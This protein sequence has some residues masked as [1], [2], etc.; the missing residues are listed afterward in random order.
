LLY[1][2]HRAGKK[3][4]INLCYTLNMSEN[5]PTWMLWRSTL[6]RLGI[7]EIVALLLEGTGSM[8]VLIAQVV[9]LSQPLLSGM[10]SS[11][12]LSAFAQVIENPT[13]RQKLISYLREAPTRA[14]S[15]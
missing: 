4:E 12:T 13:D 8:S 5:Q 15:A 7:N 9:Y 3:Y 1:R 10:I 6:Q 2:Q 14:T 11:H